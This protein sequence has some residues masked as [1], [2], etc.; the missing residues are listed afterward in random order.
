MPETTGA[1]RSSASVALRASCR[2]KSLACHHSKNLSAKIDAGS[3]NRS[4]E[5]SCG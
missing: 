4:D 1:G 3:R 5:R 2:E